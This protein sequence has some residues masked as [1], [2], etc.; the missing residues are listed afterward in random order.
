MAWLTELEGVCKDLHCSFVVPPKGAFTPGH[1]PI[2]NK[3]IDSIDDWSNL[4]PNVTEITT[5]ERILDAAEALMLEK[6]FHS[7]GLNEI[8]AAVKVPKG[9]FYH[10]FKSK[11]QFG[12]EML[13]HYVDNAIAYKTRMLLSPKAGKNALKRLLS[14]LEGGTA[15]CR[16]N[17][18]KC[19]CLLVK[20]SSEVADFSEPMRKV[21]AEG[22]R[23]RTAIL[24]KLL[25]EGIENGDISQDIDPRIMA[26]VIQDLWTG[27]TQSAAIQ[28]DTA[29]LQRVI[30]Y[31]KS[32][33]TPS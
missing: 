11:E 24:E 5:K 7:V 28:R 22:N 3:R 8:L 19:P 16:A 30:G 32:T 14:F 21:L 25:R 4:L 17:G 31:I 13:E 2:S 1:S 18:G 6:S 29:P 26:S 20:L 15:I 33:L 27:A 12:V 9:S 10:Y 23:K